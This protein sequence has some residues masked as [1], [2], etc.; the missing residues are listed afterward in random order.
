MAQG[1][2]DLNDLLRELRDINE[3][4]AALNM[5]HVDPLGDSAGFAT[6]G[7]DHSRRF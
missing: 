2:H 4:L 6:F 7:Q 1:D 5:G 3:T